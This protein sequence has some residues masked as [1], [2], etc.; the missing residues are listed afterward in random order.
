MIRS[1]YNSIEKMQPSKK[2]IHNKSSTNTMDFL[3]ASIA[4]AIHNTVSISKLNLHQLKVKQRKI[5]AMFSAKH[6]FLKNQ[7]K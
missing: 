6:S 2:H 1:A 3:P 5:L 7:V 4:W